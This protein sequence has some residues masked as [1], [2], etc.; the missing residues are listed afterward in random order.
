MQI[1]QSFFAGHWFVFNL[2]PKWRPSATQFSGHV[3]RPFAGRTLETPD[4]REPLGV[5]LE[6]PYVFSKKTV[7]ES[8]QRFASGSLT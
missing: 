7:S 3:S 8:L 1:I 4:L 6:D 5:F 2:V